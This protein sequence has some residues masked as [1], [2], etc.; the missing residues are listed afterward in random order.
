MISRIQTGSITRWWWTIDKSLLLLSL[1]LLIVGVIL[2]FA[3]SPSVAMHIGRLDSYAFVKQHISFACIA[4]ILIL[5]ISFLD[6]IQLRN[7][8]IGLAILSF[9]LLIAVLFIGVETKGSVR[10]LR[11]LGL[12]I[13][14]SEIL[15]P[16]FIVLTSWLFNLSI[17]NGIKVAKWWSFLIYA[18]CLMLLLKEPDVGQ[19]VLITIV[20]S[21]MLFL[22][23][24]SVS[25][26]LA[27]I[28]GLSGLFYIVYLYS[29][30]VH[31][32]V[33]KFLTGLGDTFQVDMGREAILHG[34]WFGVGPGEGTIKRIIPDSHT[35]FI[36]SVAAEEYGIIACMFISLAFA[37]I[38]VRAMLRVRYENN[39]FIKLTV[40]GLATQLGVQ[41]FINIGVNLHLLPAKGMTLPFI[42]YGGSSMMSVALILGALLSLT[43]KKTSLSLEKRLKI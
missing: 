17:V 4:S 9:I 2:S 19:A 30:H 34:G 40:I 16:S 6:E 14:P 3:A 29:Y 23:N 27:F 15:K 33:Q 22:A 32:R 31:I 36:F 18:A 43:R 35:D 1:V 38:V 39:Y 13:E 26:I 21:I 37:F 42:S 41:S 8:Y 20:W 11:I 10:W 12:T 25:Y 7:L 5:F 24:I 28:G